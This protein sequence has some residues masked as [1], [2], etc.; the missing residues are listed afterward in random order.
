MFVMS[1]LVAQLVSADPCEQPRV[2]DTQALVAAIA[3]DRVMAQTFQKAAS[4]CAERGEACDQ[5]RLECATLLTSTIQKQVGFD[6]GQ[7]LRDMLLPYIGASYPMTRTFGAAALA[8]DASCNVDVPTLT[9]AAQRRTTQATRRDAIFQEY[10]GYARWTQTQLQKCK[11]RA[12]SD[13]AKN[14]QAKAE[15]ERLA[16]AAAAATAAEAMKQKQAE[17]AARAK[18]EADRRAKELADAEQKRQQELKDAEAKRLQEQKDAAA[19][20]AKRREEAEKRALADREED[21]RRA[22][23]RQ[24]A[25]IEEQRRQTQAAEEARKKEREE[26]QKAAQAA[27]EAAEQKRKEEEE[28]RFVNERDSKVA[29]QRALKDRLI[30]D[31]EENLKRAKD[32]EA[33]KKQAAV[34]AVSSSPAIAAAAVNEAAQAE[35]NRVDAEKRLVTARQQADAIIID[36]GFERNGG[37]V[38][39]AGGGSYVGFGTGG[40][41]VGVQ[42][43]AHFGFWGQAPAEGMASGL[44]LKLWARYFAQVAGSNARTFDTL[45]AARYFFGRFGVGLGGEL[46]LEEPSFGTIRGGAGPSLAVAFVDT[47]EVR[48]LLGAHYLV[49]GNTI[50]PARIVGEFEVGWRFI[51]VHVLGGSA[52]GTAADGSKA[53]GWQLGAFAGVRASW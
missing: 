4:A 22:D 10:G 40:F 28:K 32:E 47:K 27:A 18:A 19:T 39:I 12:Q 52:T 36:S 42:G 21:R 49:L 20:E 9:A 26:S 31:A 43:G 48:V 23:L 5:A 33:L 51:V 25:L 37:D 24:T 30:K 2:R 53:I 3:Q 41:G 14:A 17:E 29:Q 13:E 15:T 50:D 11:E 38:F 16:A 45:V 34:D 8:T 44:E 35:K 6:E 7:W 46:R 1:M